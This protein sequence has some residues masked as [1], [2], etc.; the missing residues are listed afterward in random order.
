MEEECSFGEMEKNTKHTDEKTKRKGKED[1]FIRMETSTKDNLLM[2]RR[3]DEGRISILTE[4]NMLGIERMI[5]SMDT[6]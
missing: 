6:E 1:S 5:N 3:T 4:R 2:V